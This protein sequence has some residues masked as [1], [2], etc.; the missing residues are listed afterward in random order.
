MEVD[1]SLRSRLTLNRKIINN[2]EIESSDHEYS[3]D[4]EDEVVEGNVNFC[5]TTANQ[6]IG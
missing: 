2:T 1:P 4:D 3:E 6:T 5:M